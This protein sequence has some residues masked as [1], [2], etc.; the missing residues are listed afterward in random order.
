V[1]NFPSVN[2]LAAFA[3]AASGA[4]AQSS[5]VPGRDLLTYPIGLVAEGV[6]IPGMLGLG[7]FNPAIARLPADTAWRIAA[8]AMNTPADIAAS[9]QA[10]G[11]SG[12]WRRVTL[13][14]SLLRSAV[15]GIVSTESDP[16][17]TG[18]NI[19]YSTQVMSLGAAMRAWKHL[20]VGAALR[21]RTGQL[22]IDR[23]T[24]FSTDIGVVADGLTP[25]DIRVGASSFLL[26]PQPGAE[27]PTI[28]LSADG[29]VASLDSVR[30]LRIGA[31]MSR[32]EGRAAE[33]FFFASLRYQVWEARVGTVHTTAFGESNMRGRLGVGVHYGSYVVGIAREGAPGGLPPSYQFVLSALIR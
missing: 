22:D 11:A 9:A 7:F 15:N 19:T 5:A 25:L 21:Y 12:T 33:E 26:S 1:R 14:A 32:T 31:S 30:T 10:F 18:N 27:S 2:V 4:D 6:A 28:S 24:S 16:V 20:T 13:T 17:T 29:R 23:R 8:A 3:L